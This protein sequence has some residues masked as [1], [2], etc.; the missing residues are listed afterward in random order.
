[1]LVCNRETHFQMEGK[2][3]K[4]LLVFF[5][6]IL[7][8]GLFG[9]KNEQPEKKALPEQENIRTLHEV[10]AVG[11]QWYGHIPVW[12]GIEKGIFN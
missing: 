7:M 11:S 9:C 1:M 8:I 2:M 4:R 6:V 3:M 5:T 12:I 10:T